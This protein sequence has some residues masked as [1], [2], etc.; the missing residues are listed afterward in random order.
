MKRSRS[1]CV[2]HAASHGVALIDRRRPCRGGA[3]PE[4]GGRSGTQICGA[5]H[6]SLHPHRASG[7]RARHAAAA[8]A[9]AKAREHRVGH[10]RRAER[11]AAASVRRRAVL[12]AD[13][14]RTRRAARVRKAAASSAHP[15]AAPQP[16]ERAG[17]GREQRGGGAVRRSAA[18][19]RCRTAALQA[20]D[21]ARA[22][23]DVGEL[24]VLLHLQRDLRK[25]R[26]KDLELQSS[27]MLGGAS[28]IVSMIRVKYNG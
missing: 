5:A 17:R 3:A 14:R 19:S 20:A 23:E 28:Q 26:R 12:P 16:T 27:K 6:P 8:A 15:A 13:A 25:V 7:R 22:N 9:A 1:R 18:R 11:R 10:L 4:V 21:E 2:E 24:D